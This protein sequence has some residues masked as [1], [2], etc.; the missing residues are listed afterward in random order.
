MAVR[1]QSEA[2]RTPGCRERLNWVESGCSA[3]QE[4]VV[5]SCRGL[6]GGFLPGC[7]PTPIKGPTAG[8]ADQLTFS[9]SE[10]PGSC[11]VHPPYAWKPA[12]R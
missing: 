5:Q 8:L 6:K 3:D 12:S 4:A 7:C 10:A 11:G 1:Y 9:G 2:A